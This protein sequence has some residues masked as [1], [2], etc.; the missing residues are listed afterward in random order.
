L[1]SEDVTGLTERQG[2]SPKHPA[3]ARWRDYNTVEEEC[4]VRSSSFN[5]V[6]SGLP[7]E[8]WEVKL[9]NTSSTLFTTKTQVVLP[10][11]PS[12][13]QVQALASAPLNLA[14][15]ALAC[16]PANPSPPHARSGRRR[17]S[18]HRSRCWRRR[19]RRREGEP[20]GNRPLRARMLDA[21]YPARAELLWPGEPGRGH[22]LEH[23]ETTDVI[24][25][26][27][28]VPFGMNVSQWLLPCCNSPNYLRSLGA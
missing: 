4:Q 26:Q 21:D 9:K 1:E 8:L 18:A 20:R 23:I 22:R 25:G 19:A 5:G 28:Q 6:I 2:I 3:L 24:E 11:S 10:L 14:K 15:V 16:N 27:S 17:G 7:D 12:E 13:S